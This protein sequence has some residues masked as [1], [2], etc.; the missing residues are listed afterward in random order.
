MLSRDQYF[1]GQA[2]DE[3]IYAFIRRHWFSYMPWALITMV[4][5]ILPIIFL[6]I[7]YNLEG[8]EILRERA[9]YIVIIVSLYYL[10][11]LAFFITTWISFYLD[12]TII[13]NR[14]LVDIEQQGLFNRKISEQSLLRV[15]DVSAKVTGIFQT[16]FNYG[17]VLVETAGEEPNFELQNVPQPDKVA[18]TISDLH[19]GL[20]HDLGQEKEAATGETFPRNEQK[21]SQNE[22]KKEEQGPPHLTA[23]GKFFPEPSKRGEVT[24]EKKDHSLSEELQSPA[25]PKESTDEEG[26]LNEGEDIKL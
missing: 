14:R 8:A 10:F 26:T 15:Q 17:T 19:K 20:I 24:A 22:E 11:V 9:A 21:E 1:P 13:T 4:F 7:D 25:K 2:P 12:V 3:K 23:L 5:V 18:L 6:L 16:F